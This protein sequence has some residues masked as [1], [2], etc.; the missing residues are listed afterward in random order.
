MRFCF[1]LACFL[2]LLSACVPNKKYVYLQKNDV[3]KKNLPKDTAV[4]SYNL[5]E[6]DYRIQP[7]DAL[8]IRFA[9]ITPEEFDFLSQID[10]RTGGGGTGN[11]AFIINSELVNEDGYIRFPEIGTV[12]VSGMTIF[13][14]QDTLQALANQYLES[15]IVRVRLVNFRF[16]VLGEVPLEGTHVTLNN[17]VTLPEALGLAGGLGELADRENIKIIRQRDGIAQVA[18]VNLLDENLVNSPYYYINQGDV[19]IVPALKQRPFRKYF[20]PNLA[21][22][23]SS[24]SILLLTINLIK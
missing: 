8:F 24:I 20:G 6:F 14:I 1:L 7:N 4:R 18:Y 12:K 10:D 23:V 2:G 9:S 13:Q 17:R 21:L 11:N 22:F 16:T 3:N 5:S 19:F 15:P